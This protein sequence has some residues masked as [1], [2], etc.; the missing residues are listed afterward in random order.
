MCWY[1]PVAPLLLIRLLRM[2][3]AFCSLPAGKMIV[4]FIQ[5]FI[6]LIAMCNDVFHIL[7]YEFAY[8][9]PKL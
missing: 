4:M 5:L 7:Y 8:Y 6:T 9:F 1:L 3:S 2:N